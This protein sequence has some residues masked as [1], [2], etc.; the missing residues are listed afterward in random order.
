MAS[1]SQRRPGALP[2][3]P[4]AF[5]GQLV[6]SPGHHRQTGARAWTLPL[7]FLGLSG[8][9][10]LVLLMLPADA[11]API[12]GPAQL[13][14]T[15]F[16]AVC[17]AVRWRK[18]PPGRARWAWACVTLALVSYVIGDAIIAFL[19]STVSNSAAILTPSDAFTLPAYPIM[20]LGVLL[21]PPSAGSSVAHQL[22]AVLDACIAVG[23]VLGV[24]FV[25]FIVPR[26]AAGRL[27]DFVWALYPI[28]D[29]SIELLFLLLL[30]RGIRPPYNV[31]CTWLTLGM[32]LLGFAD[33]SFNYLTLPKN[34]GGLGL[35]SD[36]AIG[37]P[38]VA[39]AYVAAPL[40]FSLAGLQGSQ[41]WDWLE[42]L[43]TRLNSAQ[44]TNLRNQLILLFSTF[45]FL[46]GLLIYAE[47][48]PK[49]I[50]APHL[51]LLIL[52]LLVVGFFFARQL[53]TTRNL[54]D[55]RTA[56]ERAE[57]LDSLKDQF[58]INVS[59]EMRT[60]IM[61]MCSYLENLDTV[62]R[63]RQLAPAQASNLL[64]L[65]HQAHAVLVQV[66][67][68]IDAQAN[69]QRIARQVSWQE[70]L[71]ACGVCIQIAQL[72]HQQSVLSQEMTP[73]RERALGASFSLARLL[74]HILEARQL[75][76]GHPVMKP[77]IVLV[78]KVLNDA[79]ALLNPGQRQVSLLIPETVTIWG[80]PELLQQVLANLLSNAF[81]YSP[82]RPDA[83]V[84]V[85]S[86]SVDK[87]GSTLPSNADPSRQ[88]MAEIVVRDKG[89]GIPPSQK[90]LLF[91]R[92]ARLPRDL[93]SPIPGSGLGLHLCKTYVESMGGSI[94]VESS[95]EPGEGAA[96]H[97][98]LPVPPQAMLQS[99]GI[100]AQPAA[101]SWNSQ[102]ERS[103]R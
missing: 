93:A 53:L 42:R 12:S 17:S 101:V 55:A 84:T 34:V 43:T 96:F 52:T 40:A 16:A 98:R 1:T 6:S 87:S 22:A 85:T 73:L 23:A 11:R 39:F 88:K 57:H 31:S 46:G 68:N 72:Y 28:L 50:R 18:T 51:A 15:L 60:P 99:P 35:F 102:R 65:V 63:R 89:L 20:L 81:K 54:V 64:S 14:G 103:R 19:S 9:L 13:L 56:T 29:T 3:Q 58:I 82:D 74:S 33:D 59:H 67:K 49:E 21:F 8:L 97:V 79:L 83:R 75:D 30:I 80:S 95:G 62:E 41:R 45:V 2:A 61:T 100:F 92:F 77:Q 7:V 66:Q 26:T 76:Q 90:D 48:N 25:F 10:A 86:Y 71:N 47:I 32:L 44:W 70:V 78:W 94:W 91:G 27:E 37:T 36:Q 38:F 24:G 4:P 5:P 69:N